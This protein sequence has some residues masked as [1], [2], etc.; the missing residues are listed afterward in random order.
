MSFWIIVQVAVNVLLFAGFVILL[1]QR[2]QMTKEDHRFS[3]GLQLLQSKIAILEDLSDQTEAQVKTLTK[4][5]EDKYKEIQALLI[6]TDQQIL[7]ME[8]V[9]ENTWKQIQN[10]GVVTVDSSDRQNLS[11]YVKAAQLANSGNA[12]E[13][14]IKQVDLTRGEI[15]LIHAMNKEQLVFNQNSLPP[16]AKENVVKP[17]TTT[18]KTISTTSGAPVPTMTKTQTM[19]SEIT[20]LQQNGK[21]LNIRPMSFEKIQTGL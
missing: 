7:R 2:K 21:T 11:K 5:L 18:N 20:T 12:V 17:N 8:E 10:S 16:W 9:A 19:M 15:E 6:E 13:D 3:K 1:L 4:L 14:I